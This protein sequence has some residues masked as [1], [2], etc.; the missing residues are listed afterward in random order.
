MR[1]FKNMSSH[2]KLFPT[3]YSIQGIKNESLG[4]DLVLTKLAF[5]ILISPLKRGWLIENLKKDT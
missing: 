1:W 4:D 3:R 2:R 5:L